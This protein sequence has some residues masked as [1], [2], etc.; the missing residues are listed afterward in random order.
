MPVPLRAQ[1]EVAKRVSKDEIVAT[2]PADSLHEQ[3]R[4]LVRAY[5][6]R[7]TTMR[8]RMVGGER[9]SGIVEQR[10]VFIALHARPGRR[11]SI[12]ELVDR[13]VAALRQDSLYRVLYL[14]EFELGFIE[15][16]TLELA[17]DRR[18]VNLLHVRYAQT[19]SGAVEEHLLF[20]LGADNELVEVPIVYPERDGL[21]EEGEYFCCGSFTSFDE[22]DITHRVFIT[23][24]GRPGITHQVRS[25][26]ELQGRFEYD[27]ALK[28]Y[29]P[30]FRLVA[31]DTTGR[32]PA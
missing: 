17:A 22:D 11:S 29:V 15:L 2:L 7:L 10:E 16:E 19:G 20:A 6:D 31:I 25:R 1:I 32:E 21:L 14:A 30:R 23:R 12:Y 4:E 28:E 26:F 5:M 8:A 9:H 13:G 24:S 27:P 18:S 3:A